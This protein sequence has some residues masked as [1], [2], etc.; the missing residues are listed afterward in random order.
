MSAGNGT[1]TFANATYT[2]DAMGRIATVGNSADTLTYSYMPGTG[3]IASSSWETANLDTSYTYDSYKRLTNIAV[4]DVNIYGYTLN[5][6]NQRTGATLPD[7]KM[8]SYS[9]DTLGQL[10]GAVKQDSENT[11]LADLSY[12]YDQI[13]NRTSATENGTTTSYTSN[14]VNQYIQIAS[15]VPTYDA[16]GNMTSYNG[17]TYTWNGE[18][19]LI[20]AENSDTR[21]EFSYDFLGRRIE[22]KVYSKGLLSLYDWSLEKHRKFAYHGYKLIAEFDALESDALVASY[23]WQPESVGL[24]VPLMR[25]A[26][27]I[28]AYYITDG[29][30]NIIALKD[31][32][33]VNLATY[34]YSPFGSMRPASPIWI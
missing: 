28:D 19:R 14:L 21:L 30:K 16:D 5:D 31:A 20:A 1:A 32:E 3:M 4:N 25:I 24:D 6:K 34:S 15:L 11:Q 9:Y 13:G 22:K 33:G 8:W 23:L 12:L 27:G 18:K 17:W 29:N 2:Y 7:G 26:D 10:T